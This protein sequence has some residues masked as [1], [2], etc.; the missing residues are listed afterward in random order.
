MEKKQVR[1]EELLPV[2]AETLAA[3]GTVR[4][5]ITGTSMLP[6][7]AAGRDTVV[8]AP[9]HGP[10]QTYDLPLYRRENGA[11]VLHR[12]VHVEKDGT[13]TCCGDNQW[14]KEPGIQKDQ[15]IGVTA[16]ICRKGKEFP[17]TAKRYR[18]YVRLWAMLFPVRRYLVALR[19]KLQK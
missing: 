4:L 17:V 5:P 1:L 16:R 18:L 15:L 11:F 2:I 9:V 13:Y 3:G 6:L 14:V 7:L 8:L 19:G 12:V 10:L